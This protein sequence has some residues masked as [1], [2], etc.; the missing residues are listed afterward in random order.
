MVGKTRVGDEERRRGRGTRQLAGEIG[1]D[2]KCRR[3]E[4]KKERRGVSATAIGSEE[5]LSSIL[6]SGITTHRAGEGASRES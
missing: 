2:E 3:D 4:K 5:N 1:A 6:C